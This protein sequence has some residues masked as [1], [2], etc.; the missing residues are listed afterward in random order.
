MFFVIVL[1]KSLIPNTLATF[2]FL[3]IL[4]ALIYAAFLFIISGKEVFIET[5][6]MILNLRK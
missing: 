3:I 5:K 2:L 4:G 1:A 6:E